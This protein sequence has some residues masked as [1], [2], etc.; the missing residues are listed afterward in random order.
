MSFGPFMPCSGQLILSVSGTQHNYILLI[1]L[2]LLLAV[3]AYRLAG[4]GPTCYVVPG[5]GHNNK[6]EKGVIPESIYTKRKDHAL[7]YQEILQKYE[8]LLQ[9][10]FKQDCRKLLYFLTYR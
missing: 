5:H 4:A 9:N 2:K 7:T 8:T 3:P 10:I 6:E 1:Y